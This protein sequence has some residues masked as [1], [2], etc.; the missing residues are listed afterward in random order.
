MAAG[1]Q[2]LL[3]E[4]MQRTVQA[5]PSNS[6]VAVAADPR[7]DCRSIRRS[8][9]VWLALDALLGPRPRCSMRRFAVDWP[10]TR[11][12]SIAQ[13]GEEEKFIEKLK[14]ATGLDSTNKDAALLALTFFSS[15]SDDLMGRLELM[16]N[17]LYADPLDPNAHITLARH[18]TQMAFDQARA[19][20]RVQVMIL[21]AD[22]VR[23]NFRTTI[24]ALMLDWRCEGAKSPSDFIR[25]RLYAER[26]TAARN[27]A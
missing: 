6:G 26:N 8:R 13:R 5:D 18:L 17:L 1:D 7:R 25:Q 14:L 11:R 27:G 22:G 9:N 12:C 15:R 23:S 20:H 16:T 21:S 3:L 10:L 24:E 2:D 19:F 4:L